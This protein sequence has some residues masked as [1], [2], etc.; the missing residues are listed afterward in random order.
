[1]KQII[2]TVRRNQWMVVDVHCDSVLVLP[3]VLRSEVFLGIA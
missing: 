2:T 3:I 1:M